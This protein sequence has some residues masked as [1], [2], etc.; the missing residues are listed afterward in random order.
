MNL[1]RDVAEASELAAIRSELAFERD[2]RFAM[3]EELDLIW[4]E[5]AKLSSS[6]I[7]AGT[8]HPANES[9]GRSQ[10]A[11]A[12]RQKWFDTAALLQ[13]GVSE[14]DAERLRERY[15]AE[16][17]DELYLRDV[18]TREGWVSSARYRNELRQLQ[19]ELRLELGDED[20]DRVMYSSGRKNRVAVGDVL[21][22]SVAAAVG[23]R[24]GDVIV[25][26]GGE[27]ML[28]PKELRAATV[29]GPAAQTTPIDVLRGTETL[30]FYV[31]RGPLGIRI[32]RTR[33]QPD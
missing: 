12:E 27:L 14:H 4:E 26:Y 19:Q 10:Q 1:E 23:L 13:A 5:L 31:P 24:T 11:A 20:Y 17:L 29:H 16:Q 8:P 21:Q 2:A 22:N 6:P 28:S 30:R 15:E 33:R 3:A 7:S 25:R 9:K 18:A 32:V